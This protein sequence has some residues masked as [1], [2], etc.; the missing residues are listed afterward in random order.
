MELQVKNFFK[1]MKE[2]HTIYLK[3]QAN[4]PW[5]W[6]QD[7][8]LQTYK[9]CNIFRELD[10][11]TRWINDNWRV[12]FKDHP[13]LWFAMAVAR[14]INWPDTL[15]EIGFP[16]KW[17]S[18]RVKKIMYA[19][20]KRKQKVYTGAYMLTGGATNGKGLDKNIYTV[21]KILSPLFKNKKLIPQ[22]GDTLQEAWKRFLPCMGFGPFIAFEV[23]TDLRH[24]R[25]LKDATDIHTWANAGPG[26]Y[27]G[28]NRIFDH[29]LDQ[30]RP[31]EAL[32]EMQFLLRK[33]KIKANWPNDNQYP[34]LEMRDIEHTL[35]EFDKYER[36]RLGEGRPRAKYRR[37]Q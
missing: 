1:F 3:R 8:I 24:T 35:C 19:R 15:A 5:P 11:V 33:S 23:I 6:T 28:L 30:K 37:P 10:T 31:S 9:F 7:E 2:R 29:K 12:P 20:Q 13:N 34:K 4:K 26:A 32:S 17:D 21:D 14:Q 18:R 16:L 25:Y 27:R 22:K 36:V